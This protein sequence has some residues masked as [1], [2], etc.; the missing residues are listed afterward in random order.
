MEANTGFAPIRATPR[1]AS[2]RATPPDERPHRIHGPA[3]RARRGKSVG[4]RTLATADEH[5]APLA[6]ARLPG[7]DDA[8]AV[9]AHALVQL[10]SLDPDL[11]RAGACLDRDRQLPLR[12]APAP[13]LPDGDRQH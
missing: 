8:G 12:A 6:C 3:R 4:V 11:A 9:R 5:R 7:V 1:W 10:P 13:D 2:R